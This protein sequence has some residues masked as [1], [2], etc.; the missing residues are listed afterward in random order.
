VR[1][2]SSTGPGLPGITIQLF[3]AGYTTPSAS[4]VTDS[5]GAYAT[6]FLPI[7]GDEMIT[8][9]PLDAAYRF[10][11]THYFWRHYHGSEE[12]LRDFSASAIEE[13]RVYLP[14]M[15]R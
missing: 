4:A 14:L 9:R 3:L 8:V 2:G 5:T 1:L 15:L 6:G 10:D 11:P 7:P 12:A 13:S